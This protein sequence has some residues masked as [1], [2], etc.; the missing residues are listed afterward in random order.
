MKALYTVIRPGT[1]E[2]HSS[3]FTHDIS[4]FLFCFLVHEKTESADLIT[5]IGVMSLTSNRLKILI[6]KRWE[7]LK[8][9][10]SHSTHV[11][12]LDIN[13]T[14]IQERYFGKK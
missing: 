8:S 5:F 11:Q 6:R 13:Y 12:R 1:V 4:L 2:L 7:I 14:L 9:K 10:V 3:V